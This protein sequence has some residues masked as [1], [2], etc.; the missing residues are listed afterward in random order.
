MLC[1]SGC[2]PWLLTNKNHK[3]SESQ[4][5][6]NTSLKYKKLLHPD[7]IAPSIVPP[8][9]HRP[10]RLLH[11]PPPIAPLAFSTAARAALRV[12]YSYLAAPRVW[13][14]QHALR[15]SY[16]QR[17]P[18]RVWCSQHEGTLARWR[19]E[20]I[21]LSA[22]GAGWEYNIFVINWFYFNFLHYPNSIALKRSTRAPTAPLAGCASYLA[23][24]PS[25]PRN[26]GWLLCFFHCLGAAGV[27]VFILGD[28]A[29]LAVLIW[30][31]S[32]P[33]WS[34]TA[35][36]ALPTGRIPLPCRTWI[37]LVCCCVQSL[38]GGHLKPR[39]ILLYLIFCPQIQRPKWYISVLHHRD[40][41]ACHPPPT[42]SHCIGR[43]LVGCC[44]PPSSGSHQNLRP[45]CSLYFYFLLAQFAAPNNRWTSSPHI[46]TRLHLLFNAP[47][48]CRRW[49]PT[50]GC[51]IPPLSGSHPRPVLRPSLIFLM[52]AI[53]APQ[54]RES[55]A[56]SVNPAA[57]RLQ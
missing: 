13:C 42:I 38:I 47:P 29:V 52:V 23:S 1:Y 12:S 24:S 16:S 53:S 56:A 37:Y 21:I 9:S 20:S 34:N 45:R 7:D 18:L 51:C 54:S 5:K 28:V 14:S 6:K 11:I 4:A 31:W 25:S 2:N 49:Q 40:C 27:F 33:K 36:P 35:P 26:F 32:P 57:R 15:V 55:A 8:P 41:P 44:V 19:W 10:M 46:P 22:G 48:H 17:R 3:S 39:Q 43:L 50:V 30:T